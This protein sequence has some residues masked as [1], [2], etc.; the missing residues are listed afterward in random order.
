[1]FDLE[2]SQRVSPASLTAELATARRIEATMFDPADC[3]AISAYIG[4][5]EQEL[6]ACLIPSD[7]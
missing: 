6:A 2:E 1:M 3:K 4:E 5:L 7:G